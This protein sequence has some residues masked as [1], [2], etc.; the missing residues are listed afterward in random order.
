MV[1][2]IPGNSDEQYSMYVRIQ[3]IDGLWWIRV[4]DEM[5]GYYEQDFDLLYFGAEWI[6]MGGVVGVHVNVNG[7]HT[8]TDMGSSTL[9]ETRWTNAA[10][11]RNIRVIPSDNEF[12]PGFDPG[13]DLVAY[14]ENIPDLDCY[15]VFPRFESGNEWDTYFYYGGPGYGDGCFV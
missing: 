14:T 5:V 7:A 13:N 8:E 2:S 1:P 10:Y 3:N 6:Q 11:I 15:S 4:N 12:D 9:G